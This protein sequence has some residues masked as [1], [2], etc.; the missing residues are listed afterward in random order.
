MIQPLTVTICFSYFKKKPAQPSVSGLCPQSLS[1]SR[2]CRYSNLLRRFSL[3][4]RPESSGTSPCQHVRRDCQ[5]TVVTE[6]TSLPMT[7][8]GRQMYNSTVSVPDMMLLKSRSFAGIQAPSVDVGSGRSPETIHKQLL[9]AR[10]GLDR[11]T[12]DCARV[13]GTRSHT[14]NCLR[15]LSSSSDDIPASLGVSL[16]PRTQTSVPQLPRGN[17]FTNRH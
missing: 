8:P 3:E 13:V 16:T 11:H 14:C 10:V 4:S 12:P 2:R 17:Y 6:I 5:H 7:M 1:H 9:K 15:R